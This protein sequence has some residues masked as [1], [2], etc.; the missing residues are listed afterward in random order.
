MSDPNEELRHI[1]DQNGNLG[2]PGG[3]PGGQSA[4]NPQRQLK[5]N[6]T[7]LKKT[8]LPAHR[9]PCA[10]KTPFQDNLKTRKGEYGTVEP[11]YITS[12]LTHKKKNGK[13]GHFWMFRVKDQGSAGCF[14]GQNTGFGPT[15]NAAMEDASKKIL[16]KYD[17]LDKEI[18]DLYESMEKSQLDAEGESKR[19]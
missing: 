7:P 12:K 6:S 2:S 3:S 18:E 14:I 8:T 16:K 11:K 5:L 15:K 1:C 19:S 4:Q 9:S 13:Q 10:S 17:A